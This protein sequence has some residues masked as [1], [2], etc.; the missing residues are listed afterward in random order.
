VNECCVF[1]LE[2]DKTVSVKDVGLRVLSESLVLILVK[3]F[4]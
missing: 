3:I 4:R 1:V 2:G